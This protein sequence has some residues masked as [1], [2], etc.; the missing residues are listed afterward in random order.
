MGIGQPGMKGARPTLVPATKQEDESEI[1]Q[2]G[3]E[4]WCGGLQQ[5]PGHCG[6]SFA[7]GLLAGKIDGPE[8]GE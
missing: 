5:A 8:E 2:R 6:S 3:V 1:E 4:L 7:Q